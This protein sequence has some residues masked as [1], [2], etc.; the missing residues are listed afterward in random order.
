MTRAEHLA[1]AKS[2]ALEYVEMGDLNA[3]FM[4]LVS[5]LRKHPDT[6][7]HAGLA[8]GAMLYGAG[9]LDTPKAMREHIEGYQ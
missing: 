3:A 2:R 4:S 7:G 9:Q 1:W 5:D 6:E 8:L